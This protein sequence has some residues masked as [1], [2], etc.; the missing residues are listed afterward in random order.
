MEIN[1]PVEILIDWTSLN[2]SDECLCF[3][4]DGE[5]YLKLDSL[6]VAVGGDHYGI[7]ITKIDS[8]GTKSIYEYS[9]NKKVYGVQ[10]FDDTS[11]QSQ[12]IKVLEP[13]RDGKDYVIDMNGNLVTSKTLKLK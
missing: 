11:L 3:F 1:N 2:D 4:D 8:E 10:T 12:M 13:G 5:S 6:G 9:T 7:H